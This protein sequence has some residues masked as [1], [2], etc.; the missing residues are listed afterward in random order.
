VATGKPAK[1]GERPTKKAREVASPAALDKFVNP[2][3][4]QKITRLNLGIPAT[5]HAR[6]KSQCA[7]E[8]RSM[9]DVLLEMLE[10][11]FPQ[12]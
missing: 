4:E 12:K 7:L 5:L 1:W 10:A 8:G 6:I 11:Q 2:G 9:T 3:K